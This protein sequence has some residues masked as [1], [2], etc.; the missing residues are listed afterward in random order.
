MSR[1]PA[2]LL[3]LL[4]ACSPA[5]PPA[6][7]PPLPSPPASVEPPAP[8]AASSAGVVTPGPGPAPRPPVVVAMVVDQFAAWVAH[9]RLPLLPEEGGF[10][11]LRREGTWL[12]EAHH[13]HAA[14]DTAPGHSVLFT[15]AP[16]SQS[17]IF[18][19]EVLDGAKRV[20]ILRD[21]K[22]KL[23]GLKGAEDSA[24]SSL[25][26]LR[27]E[28][29][30]DKLKAKFP[31][32]F[33][34]SI[35]LKDRGALFGCGR[36]PD[37]C[38]WFDTGLD[39]FVTSTAFAE[40]LPD[41][42][43]PEASPGASVK[44]R[45]VA[46]VPLDR[47]WVEKH[48]TADGQKGEGDWWGLG[49]VFP[50]DLTKLKKPST[51]FRASP[52]GDQRVLAMASAALNHPA[53]GQVPTLLAVSLSSNDYVGHVFGPES[54]EAWD[55]LRRLDAALAGFFKKLDD[56]FGKDNYAVVL[57]ADHGVTPLPETFNVKGARPWCSSKDDRWRRPCVA[58]GRLFMDP[59]AS[60]FEKAARRALGKGTWVAGLADPY[61]FLTPEGRALTDDRRKKLVE[62]L[63]AEAL[64]NPCVERVIDVRARGA[65]CPPPTDESV[66]ALICRSMPD[67]FDGELYV[68]PK[69][70]CFFDSDYVQGSGTSHGTPH[71]YDR[72]IPVLARAPGRVAAGK[73]LDE[74]RPSSVYT[75][76]VAALLGID[77]PEAARGVSP[78]TE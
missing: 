47:A 5:A 18:G 34:A 16:P 63:T 23:V 13:P 20:S 70:G 60:I 45:E 40:K 39:A 58:G 75:A 50:H 15:G 51:A 14:T 36:K 78:L 24:G 12:T 43:L 8:P 9:E 66:D 61:V 74:A 29:L 22:T 25:A 55:H 28:T 19:N 76:T 65:S 37:G 54:W 27:V 62:A 10:A 7:A 72:T 59:M 67:R 30:A 11:R 38:I 41:W 1:R 56:R 44:A 42:A 46:W 33:V 77:P 68:L 2:A 6:P 69:V 21:T 48:A 57:G 26:R 52:A 49:R 35:S 53:A 71:L 17:G 73:V 4:G 32:S 64:K 3:L 31:D